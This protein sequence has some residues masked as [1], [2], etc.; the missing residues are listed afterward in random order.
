MEETSIPAR[1]EVFSMTPAEKRAL[2]EKLAAKN[3]GFEQASEQLKVPVAMLNL[4]L[5]EDSNP[6]P[7]RIVDGLAKMCQ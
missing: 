6:I 7:K 4:Y 1:K 3:I 2:K 5:V